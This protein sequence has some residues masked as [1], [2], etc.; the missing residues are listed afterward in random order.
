MKK[1]KSGRIV[2]KFQMTDQELKKLEKLIVEG[3][4]VTKSEALRT[5]FRLLLEKEKGR[6]NV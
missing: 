1:P 2:V 5:G 4:Y 6:D 3:R